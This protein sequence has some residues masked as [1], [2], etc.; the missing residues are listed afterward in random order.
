MA[1][2]GTV[3]NT[4]SFA[5]STGEL[6]IAA[7]RRI[8]IHRS[9]ILTEHLADARMET[10]LLQ[11]Q[12]SN[13]GPLAWTV[14]LQTVPL[15]AGQ[16]TYGVPANTVMMLDVWISIPNGDGTYTDRIITPLSRTEYAS[17]PD[18]QSEGGVTSFWFDRTISP[19]VTLW[20]VPYGDIPTMK[21]YRFTQPMDANLANVAQPQI[22]YLC[23]D[24]YVAGLSHRL[25][26]IY[27][28]ELEAPRETDAAKAAALMFSQLTDN[29]PL[30]VIPTTSSYYR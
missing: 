8:K 6:I 10:N 20:P 23:L 28:P 5:P 18:K 1:S 21:Y 22:M 26:R 30:Y 4:Y 11:V 2:I 9:E 3:S 15:I 27:A 25:A 12:W 24:A 17:L 19:T 16:A 29:T 14:D 7:F 13:L